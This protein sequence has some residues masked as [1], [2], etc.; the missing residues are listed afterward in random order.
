M[1]VF[2]LFTKLESDITGFRAEIMQALH[3]IRIDLRASVQ[4]QQVE[5]RANQ[6]DFRADRADFRHILSEAR[7][8]SS[9]SIEPTAVVAAARPAESQVPML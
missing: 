6:A 3:V 5:H 9:F 2:Y 8:S 4:V 1:G 7:A